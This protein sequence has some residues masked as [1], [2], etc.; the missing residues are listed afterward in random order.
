MTEDGGVAE[1]VSGTLTISDI[2]IGDE[3]FKS[4][5][6][7]DQSIEH[8]GTY[9]LFVNGD[10]FYEVTDGNG[11]SVVLHD[12]ISD[13]GPG[14][15]GGWSA[16]HAEANATGY[17]VLWKHLAGFYATWQTD[18]NGL[19]QTSASYSASELGDIEADFAADLNG[20]GFIDGQPAPVV[21]EAT[22]GAL[23]IDA[24][25]NWTYTLDSTHADVQALGLGVTMTDTV[26]VSAIDGTTHDIT[27]TI[28]G[29]NDA[30]VIGGVDT[31]GVT[32]DGGVAEV[33][34]GTLTISDIDTGE[35][36]FTAGAASG[37]YGSLTIDAA[38][39]W[40]YTLNNAHADVQALGLGVTT[41]DTVQIT[42]IDGTTHDITITITGTN[43]AAVIGGVDTGGVTEDGGVA[44][45]V[46]GTL[47][48]SDI[49]TGEELFT[50]GAASGTYGSLTIDAAG[51]WTYTLNNAHA[52]VQA[53]GLGVTTTDTVQITAIDGTTHDIAITI[54]GTNDAAVIGGVDT[55]GVT[56]DGGVAEV[57]SG[58]LTISDIDTGEDLFTAGGASGTYGSLTIDAAGNWTYTLN[59]AH[60]DVQA[61]GLGVTT[62]DTVQITA[63]D[64]TTHDI[65]ITITGTND[66]AVIGGVDTGSV[67]EDGGE[68]E[69][70]SGALTISDTDTGEELFTAGAASGTYG[71]VT[72][73]ASGNW[74]YTLNS[75]HADVQALGL[76]VT[77]TDTVQITA[78]DGTTHDITITITGTNDAAVI[79][80]VDTGGV[81][82]DG[83]VAE[84]VSGTL[85]ISDT[86][87]GEDLFTAGRCI[88]RLWVTHHR[89]GR[90]L[91]L[92]A[93]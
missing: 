32:E 2:D 33:V 35:E 18:T 22:Y 3:V 85:T 40:T 30:A 20:D 29:T 14:T 60:A 10:G 58:T 53:L 76:G 12:S 72:I 46:S 9:Q 7:D 57:V 38:G 79:G 81:T 52:D 26:T 63:I 88:R 16:I 13:V 23:T 41:T 45:V 42:A 84:V 59:N 47:T 91:D 93:E 17:T 55:G 82:E 44:E 51:N 61:L 24:A 28:T 77:T 69:T 36:L 67:T 62:T 21:H 68:L 50:A 39:N 73:D 49:D 89:R 48:I 27:V 71:S 15:F 78:I 43:D 5:T 90:Q 11:T 87:T 19:Y 92:Y 64:G 34:S 86:D 70:T 31:G 83:G 65:T 80:G 6:Y 74:T 75:A 4:A 56:E 66:T 54:T 25:G 8:Y 37:T 1:V